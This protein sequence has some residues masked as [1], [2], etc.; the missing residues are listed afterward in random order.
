MAFFI[1][2]P[3]AAYAV[4]RTV[5]R[6]DMDELTLAALIAGAAAVFYGGAFYGLTWARLYVIAPEP[7]FGPAGLSPVVSGFDFYILLLRVIMG[8]AV[9]FI[10]PIC[11]AAAIQHKG[12]I[13]WHL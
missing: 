9:T 1:C 12:S 7:F 13:R 4:I 3:I 10:A 5:S 11:I 2:Y 8:W 6:R